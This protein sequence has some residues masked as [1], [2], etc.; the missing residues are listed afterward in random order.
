[1]QI[2][3]RDVF[4]KIDLV[5]SLAECEPGGVA[6]KFTMEWNLNHLQQYNDRKLYLV[7][8]NAAFT[9]EVNNSTG[10]NFNVILA[11]EG[12]QTSNDIR[13]TTQPNTLAFL[14]YAVHDT[15]YKGL[16]F[17]RTTPDIVVP[18]TAIPDR[19]TF[20]LLAG[21]KTNGA[22]ADAVTAGGTQLYT[23]IDMKF[24]LYIMV[25]KR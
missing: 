9:C 17:D 12:V 11:V 8:E 24:S 18:L 6:N 13:G 23:A 5:A 21:A 16:Y 15:A 22:H 2:Q 14:P 19:V 7:L 10:N 1:M 20:R 3:E 25:D 4:R